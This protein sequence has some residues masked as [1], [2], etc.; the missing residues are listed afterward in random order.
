MSGVLSEQEAAQRI[1]RF[2]Q[3]NELFKW[4]VEG[5]SAWRLLRFWVSSRLI[6]LPCATQTVFSRT[7]R[8]LLAIRELPVFLF[9]RKASFLIDTASSARMEKAGEHYKDVF[10]DDLILALGDCFK[11][12]RINST[13]FRARN[14]QALVPSD[15]TTTLLEVLAGVLNRFSRRQPA[16]EEIARHFSDCIRRDLALELSPNQIS[17]ELHYFY[18][19]KRLYRR[20]LNKIQPQ[21]VLLTNTN[22]FA[23]LAAAR[24]LGIPTFELQHGIFS[25]HH[26][27]ALPA[28]ALVYKDTLLVPGRLLLFGEFWRQELAA[29]GFYE[30]ELLPVGSIRME[31]YRQRRTARQPRPGQRPLQVVLTTQGLAVPEL[32]AFV[33]SFLGLAKE[34]GLALELY[35]KLHPV[36][37]PSPAAYAEAFG[38]D[39]RVHILLGREMPATFDL[40]TRA[41]VHLSIASACHYDALGLGVPTIVLP[42]SG[43][44]VVENIVESGHAALA[45]TPQELL[46]LL[47]TL[48][49]RPVPPAVQEWYFKP[50][51]LEN[52]QRALQPS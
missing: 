9:P 29:G 46:D 10:F 30:D 50:G 15:L 14:R 7:Q 16:I 11:L 48:D 24:E 34:A 20:L 1:R 8:L 42:L 47:G 44:T 37:E 25:R 41:D 19:N 23:M 43:Y 2:E 49:E 12:E 6:L 45:R 51:A 52:I 26:P 5:V 27:D 38:A 35:I 13:A 22:E 36:F 33:Q 32:I 21:A 40:L 4:Q 39:A 18:W 28:E 31:Q 17:R 3:E